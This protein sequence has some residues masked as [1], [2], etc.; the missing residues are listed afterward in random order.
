M[1]RVAIIEDNKAYNQ[2]LHHL[3][4]SAEDFCVIYASHNCINLVAA[5]KE[6][7]PDVVIM[8][9]EMP[10]INGI[11]GVRLI[12]NASPDTHVF[13]LTSFEDD[14]KIFTSIKAGATGYMLKNDSPENILEAIRKI[15]KGESVMN[16]RVA[17]KVLQYFSSQQ[18]NN[19]SKMD[20]YNLTTREKQI[21]ELLNKGFSYKDIANECFISNATVFTHVK[22]IYA[23][24]N[25]HSRNE[26]AA[27]FSN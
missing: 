12:K 6:H 23:K 19:K 21:L 9:I 7:G 22:N 25:I 15:N 1:I 10:G 4:N 11:D 14:D 8:D 17:R 24:L 20:G 3:I 2:A 27:K 26:I 18:T 16:G 13:M 5:I